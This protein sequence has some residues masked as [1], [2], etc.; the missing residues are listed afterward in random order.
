MAKVYK[1]GKLISEGSNRAKIAPLLKKL[2]LGKVD[3]AYGE[4]TAAQQFG[5]NVTRGDGDSLDQAERGISAAKYSMGKL[6]QGSKLLSKAG[7]TIASIPQ[8]TKGVK[9]AS[10]NISKA[11]TK[12]N[13]I[14]TK[15]TDKIAKPL[16][17]VEGTITAA[18]SVKTLMGGNRSD[19]QMT[20][21]EKQST[22]LTGAGGALAA[23]TAATGLATGSAVG[24]TL[25]SASTVAASTAATG[26]GIGATVSAGLAA[27]GPVGWAALAIGAGA[28]ALGVFGNKS[29][30]RR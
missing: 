22:A 7:D 4:V 5:R 10:E 12:A 29:Y 2:T 8:F 9:S 17:A 19:I 24:G 20:D 14:T 28:A 1:D 11:A 26:A 21:N 15:L 13:S 16:A 25:A 6:N 23:G 18:Q 3:E 27:I 30:R